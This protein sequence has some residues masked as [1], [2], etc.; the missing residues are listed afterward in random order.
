VKAIYANNPRDLSI[1]IFYNGEFVSSRVIRSSTAGSY[2]AE[3][4]SQHFCGRRI[5]TY[6]EVP[7]V[8]L[9][10]TKDAVFIADKPLEGSSFED[11]WN[12]INQLLLAEADEWGRTGKYEMFRAPVGEYL[13]ELS[14]RPIPES[15]KNRGTVGN[16]AGIIDVSKKVPI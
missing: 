12:E 7:F 3:E 4:K 2:T 6:F 14:K 16:K 11:R 9:P 13:E 1:N 10:A 5:D 8:V 15:M